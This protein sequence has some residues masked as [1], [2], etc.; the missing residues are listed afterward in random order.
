MP[1]PATTH[2]CGEQSQGKFGRRAGTLV[3]CYDA[4]AKEPGPNCWRGV[5]RGPRGQ[6]DCLVVAPGILLAVPGNGQP[7][8][9]EGEA[10]AAPPA[11]PAR[12]TDDPSGDLSA[13]SLSIARMRWESERD[14]SR[15]RR[16]SE[17]LRQKD[18]SRKE[19]GARQRGLTA[20]AR[21]EQ[22]AVRPEDIP[23]DRG[24]E[25]DTDLLSEMDWEPDRDD[26]HTTAFRRQLS[27][28]GRDERRGGGR[29]GG[30]EAESH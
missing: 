16:S 12:T 19:A 11:T 30:K 4:A 20:P 9:G 29:E 21:P 2:L 28:N 14:A 8:N 10:E 27:S 22:D 15:A 13:S 7:A 18:R 6:Q 26:Y 5:A 3:F 25:P 23:V 24:D 17:F 1:R